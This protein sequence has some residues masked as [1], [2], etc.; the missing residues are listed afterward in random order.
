LFLPLLRRWHVDDFAAEWPRLWEFGDYFYLLCINWLL[1]FVQLLDEH[2]QVFPLVVLY[3]VIE[4][5]W[6]PIKLD[7]RH[8]RVALLSA[9][10]LVYSFSEVKERALRPLLGVLFERC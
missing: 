2:S 9:E 10:L 8:L 1:W 6:L 7:V 3:R 4:R 5:G